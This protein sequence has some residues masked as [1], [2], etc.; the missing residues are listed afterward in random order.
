[1]R[2]DDGF[3]A[4]LREANEI[5]G[6]IGSYLPLKAAGRLYSGLCPFHTEKTP[7][8]YVYPD[9]QSYYCFGCGAGGDAITFVQTRENLSY[10]EAV[11]FLC[12]RAGMAFPQ[13]EG[14]KELTDLRRRLYEVNRT[15]AKYWH[16]QLF[17]PRGKQGLDYLHKRGL[18]DET[19]RHFGL[20]WAANDW[21]QTHRYLESQGFSK[22]ELQTAW[23]AGV[24]KSGG[25]YDQFRCRVIFPIL[26][27]RGNVIAF[28]GR[29]LDPEDKRKYLNSGDTPVFKKS[30][31]LYALNFA[32]NHA[33]EGILICEGNLDVVQI[34][35][36][37]FPFAVAGLGT[38]LTPEH[39]RTLSSYTNQIILA[40]DTDEPGQKAAAKAIELAKAQ[41]LKTKV[42]SLPD[43]KDP[44]EYIK[45]FGA[46]RFGTRL[47]ESVDANSYT[48]SRLE[49][50]LNLT[51]DD[52]KVEYITRTLPKLA[53]MGPVER[54][55][56]AHRLAEKTGVPK[57]AILLQLKAYEKKQKRKQAAQDKRDLTIADK[58]SGDKI[59]PQRNT[60]LRQAKAE[61]QILGVLMKFPEE[62]AKALQAGL[63]K[64]LFCT[65]FNR[66][67]FV[68]MEAHL[69]EGQGLKPGD[70]G[71]EFDVEEIG[72]ITHLLVTLETGGNPRQLLLDCV[73]LLK[74]EQ[75]TPKAD[76]AG[77]MQDQDLL[78]FMEQLKKTKQS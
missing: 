71:N 41:G 32:K 18:S 47:K 63:T 77:D 31:T 50:G 23:L 43:A 37:G 7:S 74:H 8:F 40:Y 5:V 4:Q 67:I 27:V 9:T 35:Q 15:A 64:D 72:R 3:L 62:Y 17:S 57:D 76:Q 75:E 10:V 30:R 14:N 6:L 26:D 73:A 28:S 53:Q 24:S 44:D 68:A 55:V 54:E 29:T 38:A 48:L 36:A 16:S 45:K 51:A 78:K 33:K 60:H 34:H 65:D 52:Q 12:D 66:R 1:M 39:L 61:E 58:V 20:G 42:L 19:I 13:E 46:V 49:S 69:R 25:L 70:F 11:Q 2:F 56:Y 22:T 21:H 59:N